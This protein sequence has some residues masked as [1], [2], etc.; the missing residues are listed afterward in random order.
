MFDSFCDMLRPCLL[1]RFIHRLKKCLQHSPLCLMGLV[2]NAK[3]WHFAYALNCNRLPDYPCNALNTQCCHKRTVVKL[4]G[5][6]KELLEIY[7]LQVDSSASC[8]CI[9][10]VP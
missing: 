9:A 4:V 3:L 5:E 1:L 2:S 7:S 8:T 10:A 6:D